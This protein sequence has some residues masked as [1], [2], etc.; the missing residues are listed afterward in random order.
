MSCFC[1][2]PKLADVALRGSLVRQAQRLWMQRDSAQCYISVT[3]R[4]LLSYMQ[5]IASLLA[6]VPELADVPLQHSVAQ[7]AQRL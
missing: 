4:M 6:Q 2:R 1:E 5:L 3:L 7:Q